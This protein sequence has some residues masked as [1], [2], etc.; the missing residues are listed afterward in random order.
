MPCD[1]TDKDG[2]KCGKTHPE[3]FDEKATQKQIDKGDFTD[4]DIKILKDDLKQRL[5][6]LNNKL[7]AHNSKWV[8]T[9]PG[10]T[11]DDQHKL[12]LCRMVTWS[13]SDIKS[14]RTKTEDEAKKIQDEALKELK[15]LLGK[16]TTDDKAKEYA[17]Q[18]KKDVFKDNP[19]AAGK[20]PCP[21][22]CGM[23]VSNHVGGTAADGNVQ[24]IDGKK[25]GLEVTAKSVS[26]TELVDNLS[27]E[28]DLTWGGKWNTPDNVHW[29]LQSK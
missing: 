16:D 15:D 6:I 9:S 14:N 24:K 1:Y 12:H 17:N 23:G 26:D 13:I 3:A 27:K 11:E 8:L 19:V 5:G 7:Y 29:Q 20:S 25:K 4:D 2:N 28:S 21:C 18:Q 10:R 22:G